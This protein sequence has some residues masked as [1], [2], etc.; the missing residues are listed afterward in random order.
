MP[1]P[2]PR[3][4]KKLARE[5]DPKKAKMTLRKIATSKKAWATL[6]LLA[7]GGAGWYVVRKYMTAANLSGVGQ[8]T[9]EALRRIGR[10]LGMKRTAF[11]SARLKTLESFKAELLQSLRN[12]DITGKVAQNKMT[13]AFKAGDPEEIRIYFLKDFA[14]NANFALGY[15]R[16][17]PYKFLESVLTKRM[18]RKILV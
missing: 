11:D 4:V 2:V 13:G 12:E 15:H 9:V 8:S 7:V 18:L 16:A 3:V 14:L 6:V 1:T 5:E 17:N 10:S